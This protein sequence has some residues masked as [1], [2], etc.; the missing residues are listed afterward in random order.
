MPAAASARELEG[1]GPGAATAPAAAALEARTG[2][3]FE[4]ARTDSVGIDEVAGAE[5]AAEGIAG[6]ASAGSGPAADRV[7]HAAEED[8]YA[9]ELGPSDVGGRA[10]QL[11]TGWQPPRGK[12]IP[13]EGGWV[14]DDDAGAAGAAYVPSFG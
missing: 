7:S 5:R 1:A 14:D 10:S 8:D 4:G 12:A 9:E 13:D 6:E 3:C 11:S 2:L